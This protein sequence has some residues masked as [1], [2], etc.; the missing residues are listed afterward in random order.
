MGDKAAAVK[1]F[2]DE[3]SYQCWLPKHW[4]QHTSSPI[5]RNDLQ[6]FCS[7]LNAYDVYTQVFLKTISESS[8]NG[9]LI[10]YPR[11]I[12]DEV[13][14]NFVLK[15]Y[16][17]GE[18]QTIPANTTRE[19]LRH[20]RSDS[21]G[22]CIEKKRSLK[23]LGDILSG[24]KSWKKDVEELNH[25]Y[26]IA[27]QLLE[28]EREETSRLKRHVE[29]LKKAHYES[30]NKLSRQLKQIAKEKED[31]LIR[32]N[33]Y[34]EELCQK[35]IEV[36]KSLKLEREESS[37]LKRREEEL[38]KAHHQSESKMSRQLKQI[39][40]EKEDLLIRLSRIAGAKLTNNN[41]HIADLSDDNRPTKLAEKFGQLYD[42]AW[43]DSL[44]ELTEVETKLEDTVAIS[45]LLRITAYQFCRGSRSM[46]LDLTDCQ[47]VVTCKNSKDI[48][49]LTKLPESSKVDIKPRTQMSL[50][51]KET[52]SEMQKKFHVILKSIIRDIIR[53][54]K[55]RPSVSDTSKTNPWELDESD[56][57]ATK[58]LGL[59]SGFS[60]VMHIKDIYNSP[61][62][63]KE[64]P[65]TLLRHTEFS[66]IK[67]NRLSEFAKDDNL[68]PRSQAYSKQGF[69]LR[70]DDLQRMLSALKNSQTESTGP[71]T[72]FPKTTHFAERCVELCWFMHITQPPIHLSAC[73]P[74]KKKMNNDIFKAYMKSGTVIDYIVWPVMYLHENGPLLTKGI[75]QPE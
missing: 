20:M 16:S 37:R 27:Q 18:L 42:D 39:A 61:K 60:T 30:E 4:K 26:I 28:L 11:N 72:R 45:F 17:P 67:K 41:P 38:K 53:K 22:K 33:S 64:E 58:C 70:R 6:W 59:W 55:F 1:S 35:N 46:L 51:A 21:I 8:W 40:E 66:K 2:A 54:E 36:N 31:L 62:G 7:L 52:V 24:Y 68:R 75:A 73:I 5:S 9:E 14:D 13:F 71:K 63:S 23:K 34:F 43:T 12:E 57:K 3:Q 10:S 56:V 50:H 44:E 47:T 48:K 69:F 29:E 25:K 19:R 74:E 32:G 15:S 49:V 65:V